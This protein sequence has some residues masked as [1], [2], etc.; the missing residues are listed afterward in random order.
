M[1][2]RVV[3]VLALLACSAAVARA[4]S[5]TDPVAAGFSPRVP[6]SALARPAAWFDA[7]RLHMSSTIAMGSGWGTTS[8]LQTTSFSYQFRAPLAM[9]VSVGNQLGTGAPGQ[10]ASFFL[11]GVDL[12]WQP[13]GNS[14]VRFQ[15]TD[16]RSPLSWGGMYGRGYGFAGPN[17][18][19]GW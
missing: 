3:L 13:T 18:G 1:M 15:Y 2:R 4:G 10:S 17:G 11:Q 19:Y 5:F 8:A 16:M 14:L 12:S 7:S 6:V 9:S